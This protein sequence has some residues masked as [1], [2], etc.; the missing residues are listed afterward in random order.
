MLACFLS[1]AALDRLVLESAVLSEKKARVLMLGKVCPEHRKVHDCFFFQDLSFMCSTRKVPRI[2]R[3]LLRPL[4]RT[5]D[6]GLL[7]ERTCEM[8]AI[9]GKL[10]SEE[11]SRCPV[12]FLVTIRK[13]LRS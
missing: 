6:G 8:G 3:V 2:P 13:G 1:L 7:V 4:K 11:E 10:A 5:W 12:E 9:R